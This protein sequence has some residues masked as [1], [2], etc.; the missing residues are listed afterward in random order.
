MSQA[1]FDS[2]LSIVQIVLV[3]LA[4]FNFVMISKRGTRAILMGLGILAFCGGI[5]AYRSQ[6]SDL[7]IYGALAV[8]LGLLVADIWLHP[9][10]K[11]SLRGSRK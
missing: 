7:V 3:V 5:M 1:Q 4:A 6:Q 11:R 9:R 8:G 10:E 2:F